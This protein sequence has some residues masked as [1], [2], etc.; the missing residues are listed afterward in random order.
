MALKSVLRESLRG[1]DD[2]G[3]PVPLVGTLGGKELVGCVCGARPSVLLPR[4]QSFAGAAQGKHG[5]K[6]R[7]LGVVAKLVVLS[8]VHL[9]RYRYHVPRLLRQLFDLFAGKPLST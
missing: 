3:A 2:S 8:V 9:L 6:V 7:Y 1:S 4:E 5:N